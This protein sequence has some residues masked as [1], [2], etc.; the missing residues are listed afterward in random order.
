MNETD[1]QWTDLFKQVRQLLQEH[2]C[3]SREDGAAPAADITA[4]EKVVSTTQW[5]FDGDGLPEEEG[6]PDGEAREV[7]FLK[8]ECADCGARLKGGWRF[9]N[10]DDGRVVSVE[11]PTLKEAWKALESDYSDPIHAVQEWAAMEAD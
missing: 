3:K 8:V 7:N 10:I 5:V 4:E 9:R 6:E 1:E 2:E 11:A